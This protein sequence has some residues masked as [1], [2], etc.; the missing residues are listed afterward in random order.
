MLQGF[1]INRE[2]KVFGEL[3][4]MDQNR[5][6]AFEEVSSTEKLGISAIQSQPVV[7][8]DRS[9]TNSS[10]SKRVALHVMRKSPL[11][12]SYSN[13]IGSLKS[14][15]AKI[16]E[17]DDHLLRASG[18]ENGNSPGVVGKAKTVT[19]MPQS[20]ITTH[21][22]DAESG[23]PVSSPIPQRI[24]SIFS[25]LP[26]PL[27]GHDGLSSGFEP[28]TLTPLG[29]PFSR[30]SQ[31]R[32]ESGFASPRNVLNSSSSCVNGP[33]L[34]GRESAAA[35]AAV[36]IYEDIHSESA[37]ISVPAPAPKEFDQALREECESPPAATPW[38]SPSVAL[39]HRPPASETRMHQPQEEGEGGEAGQVL[40]EPN[41]PSYR[42]DAANPS[43]VQA[44]S[45]EAKSSESALDQISER[46]KPFQ[47]EAMT[48][49]APIVPSATARQSLQVDR[50]ASKPARRGISVDRGIFRTSVAA[51]VSAFGAVEAPQPAPRRSRSSDSGPD[52]LA[53]A[54]R[55]PIAGLSLNALRIGW[56]N[57][58][59]GNV[60][61]ESAALGKG[62]SLTE[63]EEAT[64]RYIAAGTP[65][66]RRLSRRRTVLR[67]GVSSS[68]PDPATL[69]RPLTAPSDSG[70]VFVTTHNVAGFAAPTA[71]P[72]AVPK[73]ARAEATSNV[74]A[75]IYSHLPPRNRSKSPAMD[76]KSTEN[77]NA[78]KP[79]GG[80]YKF[81]RKINRENLVPY[82]T[83]NRMMDK[84]PNQRL[85]HAE[86]AANI[87]LKPEGDLKLTDGK[88]KRDLYATHDSVS[89]P[90]SIST[91]GPSDSDV[92]NGGEAVDRNDND[93]KQED[94]RAVSKYN[95]SKV[96]PSVYSPAHQALRAVTDGQ[97]LLGAYAKARMARGNR[98]S[99]TQDA[100]LAEAIL[101]LASLRSCIAPLMSSGPITDA[102]LIAPADERGALAPSCARPTDSG[103]ARVAEDFG[104]GL[105][106]SDSDGELSSEL[107][108]HAQY[109][110]EI[111]F[112]SSDVYS[113]TA[114]VSISDSSM[115]GVA[116]YNAAALDGSVITA[117]AVC[118]G[119][120]P[121][122]R[123]YRAGD[124]AG[125]DSSAALASASKSSG[126]RK[127]PIDASLADE[128]GQS[129]CVGPDSAA[130]RQDSSIAVSSTSLSLQKSA[131]EFA[132]A[133]G[134]G[135]AEHMRYLL[136]EFDVNCI[137]ATVQSENARDSSSQLELQLNLN[138]NA[139]SSA[140]KPGSVNF[141]RT[142]HAEEQQEDSDRTFEQ[143]L[144]WAR[145]GDCKYDDNYDEEICSVE[146]SC[147]SDSCA[148]EITHCSDTNNETTQ[149]VTPTRLTLQQVLS[150]SIANKH[151]RVK[152]CKDA[153]AYAPT[154][155]GTFTPGKVRRSSEAPNQPLAALVAEYLH[156]RVGGGNAD[157]DVQ[158]RMATSHADDI[159]HLG[160]KNEIY[161]E[162]LDDSISVA[163]SDGAFS[164]D[165]DVANADAGP[166][167]IAWRD[168]Q[169]WNDWRRELVAAPSN[170]DTK[171]CV[172]QSQNEHISAPE[173]LCSSG[174]PNKISHVLKSSSSMDKSPQ[175]LTHL[176]EIGEIDDKVISL[177]SGAPLVLVSNDEV[178][179]IPS[180]EEQLDA[181]SCM[182]DDA[183]ADF[184]AFTFD[185]E[186]DFDGNSSNQLNQQ[187]LCLAFSKT[188]RSADVSAAEYIKEILILGA[189][190]TSVKSQL[191]IANKR[192]YAVR[193]S[194]RP[195]IMRFEAK[196]GYQNGE[197]SRLPFRCSAD[198]FRVTPEWALLAP[199][200]EAAFSLSFTPPAAA[201]PGK[202]QPGK[203][204]S[205]GG[206][207]LESSQARILS[208][209]EGVYSGLCQLTLSSVESKS[210]KNV[211]FSILLRG[212]A[213]DLREDLASVGN[214]QQGFDSISEGKSSSLVND[215]NRPVSY[216]YE[217]SP[218]GTLL[219]QRKAE[220]QRLR[221][222]HEQEQWMQRR[223][224]H[225]NASEQSASHSQSL[226][227]EPEEALRDADVKVSQ[228]YVT[229]KCSEPS[230]ICAKPEQ[231]S[232]D[233]VDPD[234]ASCVVN[235]S[236]G[237]VGYAY[238]SSPAG[239]LLRQR[240]AE[241]Q[242]LRKEHEQE[243]ASKMFE[244]D[245]Q[246]FDSVDP[247]SASCVVNGSNG[248]VGYAYES[249]PAGTLLRQRKADQQRLRKEHEQERASKLGA[250]PQPYLISS[251]SGFELGHSVMNISALQSQE[252]SGEVR[253]KQQSK[254]S[255]AKRRKMRLAEKRRQKKAAGSLVDD[256]S[257][258]NSDILNKL[259][260][261]HT[262]A[263]RA[264]IEGEANIAVI[265]SSTSSVRD[266]P[267]KTPTEQSG[268]DSV[269]PIASDSSVKQE[270]PKVAEAEA[271]STSLHL[272][273]LQ[274]QHSWLKKWILTQTSSS[275]SAAP[276]FR[277]TASVSPNKVCSNTNVDKLNGKHFENENSL[278]F[279]A[280][281][282]R[283]PALV[284]PA[285]REST[286]GP[287]S[288]P[289][290]V[291][292]P[293][294]QLRAPLHAK[295][296][297][298]PF[299]TYDFSEYFSKQ[300]KG[301]GAEVQS[302]E[303]VAATIQGLSDY[304]T[305]KDKF[306]P[307]T[308]MQDVDLNLPKPL[309]APTAKNVT[310]GRYDEDSDDEAQM[311]DNRHLQA[312][313][314]TGVKFALLEQ[315]TREC[316]PSVSDRQR[317]SAASCALETS[318]LSVTSATQTEAS[319]GPSRAFT[320]TSDVNRECV[321]T[322][323]HRSFSQRQRFSSYVS[324]QRQELEQWPSPTEKSLQPGAPTDVYFSRRVARFVRT[325]VGSM[326]RIKVELCNPRDEEVT[327]FL[328]EPSLPFILLHSEIQLRPRSYVRLPVRFIPTLARLNYACELTVQSAHGHSASITLEAASFSASGN[329][330]FRA[331]RK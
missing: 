245:H 136:Q 57:T 322:S 3:K 177:P 119:M 331:N 190:G 298:N 47:P 69:Q 172:S 328:L 170:N 238:E 84:P 19:A 327:I 142:V 60:A 242:R 58:V 206:E 222:E 107:R 280:S 17:R 41:S 123:A 176:N 40:L 116:Q 201:M 240:K 6:V 120:R 87:A 182:P 92:S 260:V 70:V 67:R 25:P 318:H 329:N 261:P 141:L 98:I 152:T 165:G 243:R 109:M 111:S 164:G 104:I 244:S 289:F 20:Q 105:S 181:L 277:P 114:D 168:S 175:A 95:P 129:S 214:S 139:S 126:Q 268:R 271:V 35:N 28:R 131:L 186:F 72:L 44:K 83:P 225:S 36:T 103:R 187:E 99:A 180:V 258:R 290:D 273:L 183:S 326:S 211:Q 13:V 188:H 18:K 292:T 133:Y 155:F 167:G 122:S 32:R 227:V 223:A 137:G 224:L 306:E 89:S 144:P 253:K 204:C 24:H 11:R 53:G 251:D 198:V 212:E 287:V 64:R 52:N 194:I 148:L 199:G 192:P 97:H 79:I 143:V 197:A 173:T 205:S 255:A 51:G 256:V 27:V 34:A 294:S 21:S 295:P 23:V 307:V 80:N 249:S 264:I 39:K 46:L 265:P 112:L 314:T 232:F 293:A 193:V 78:D 96:S 82:K 208:C 275:T 210:A 296:A 93:G 218:A 166:G 102:A 65:G 234:S 37:H 305:A 202:A 106:E 157:L 81:D 130:F 282:L 269:S 160:G 31:G 14:D 237:Q 113:A 300:Q 270:E 325:A 324:Q 301:L 61:D 90:V 299:D 189:P 135:T 330:P 185:D 312:V 195:V 304:G 48:Y 62:P 29:G 147:E 91:P 117:G 85:P 262:A 284:P 317:D 38:S 247:D 179:A 191:R 266:L 254:K 316:K 22:S 1:E 146:D 319:S 59:Q 149:K 2:R 171:L 178:V 110:N 145:R 7:S 163:E 30:Q 10:L 246:S 267:S 252:S 73:M 49:A 303:G 226:F 308:A 323:L 302:Q 12:T 239:T 134:K 138:T 128:R 321:G 184:T 231:L 162:Q 297:S 118:Q 88:A 150:L 320:V 291:S 161:A 121:I 313:A 8:I 250:S 140:Y 5:N 215:A 77:P 263:E 217:S 174:L 127:A 209:A 286:R 311:A 33:A 169:F 154:D 75:D 66:E 16:D 74:V 86:A 26:A 101:A 278:S 71:E 241:Q 235:G 276:S 248:Q 42:G 236:N 220:Q 213:F 108:A 281:P 288:N 158:S 219:R 50:L 283:A 279:T 159:S 221:K 115:I 196:D 94:A 156:S 100:E 132:S 124:F 309:T 233:S 229:Q 125:G 272:H 274:G 56:N 9:A 43:H 151:N 228:F 45:S 68:Q 216:D 200:A 257:G 153:A 207:H 203:D 315:N 76:A 15:K 230:H 55:R 63:E 310:R 259:E 285:P 54:G 4:P